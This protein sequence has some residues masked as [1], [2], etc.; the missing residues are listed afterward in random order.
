MGDLDY[1]IIVDGKEIDELTLLRKE[2]EESRIALDYFRKK[3]GFEGMEKLFEEEFEENRI[4]FRQCRQQSKEGQYKIA[5]TDIEVKG[6]TLKEY[7]RW[8]MQANNTNNGFELLKAHPSHWG[9]KA[10]VKDGVLK[11]QAIEWTGGYRVPALMNLKSMKDDLEGAPFQPKW[12]IYNY[13]MVTMPDGEDYGIRAMHQY[14]PIEDGFIF[15]G[16]ICYPQGINDAI[17]EE[18]KLHLGIEFSNWFKMGWEA[19]RANKKVGK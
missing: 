19:I 2:V 14:E 6:M 13:G 15:H 16:A 17:V 4:F 10:S 7:M 11:Q 8:Y 18:Q 3:L 5:K 1:R 12:P 9:I